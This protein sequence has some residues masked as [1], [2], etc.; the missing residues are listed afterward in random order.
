G[1]PALRGGA[2]G[3]APGRALCAPLPGAEG[4]AGVLYVEGPPPETALGL[5]ELGALEVLAAH[6]ALAIER[7]RLR[8]DQARLEDQRLRRLTDENEALKAR[9]GEEVPVGQSAPMRAALD[10]IRRVA[11]SEA[12]V[13]LTGET[14]TGKEVLARY[15]HRLSPRARGP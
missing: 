9:L 2:I 8:E 12:T 5:V 6:A 13:L 4:P 3:E 14:G 7:A 11:P 10:L 15:L 1:Q